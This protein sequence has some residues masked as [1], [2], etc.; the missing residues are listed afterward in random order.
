MGREFRTAQWGIFEPI[1][2]ELP[3]AI[4]REVVGEGHRW[5]KERTDPLVLEVVGKN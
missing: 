5:P 1:I 4:F 3:A 2:G